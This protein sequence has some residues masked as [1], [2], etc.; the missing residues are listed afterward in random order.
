MHVADW[1]R[2]GDALSR[3][4]FYAVQLLDGFEG[5]RDNVAGRLPDFF[6][7]AGLEQATVRAEVGTVL[8]TLALYSAVNPLSKEGESNQ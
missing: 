2:P 5:T 6:S 8:G 7:E 3:A 4:A 1:G